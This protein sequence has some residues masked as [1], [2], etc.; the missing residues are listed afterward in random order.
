M[1]WFPTTRKGSL[2]LQ[3]GLNREFGAQPAAFYCA[4]AQANMMRRR[5]HG[6]SGAKVSDV[7]FKKRKLSFWI[8]RFH[9]LCIL[10]R[11]VANFSGF[12]CLCVMP[13]MTAKRVWNKV[14][15]ITCST[16]QHKFC[17][18]CVC[19]SA[20]ACRYYDRCMM[21]TNLPSSTTSEEADITRPMAD[22]VQNWHGPQ[23][24]W[25]GGSRG[26][27]WAVLHLSGLIIHSI[28]CVWALATIL[29][30]SIATKLIVQCSW[31]THGAILWCTCPL[32]VQ[33][34]LCCEP[35]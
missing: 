26:C 15:Y 7:C 14:T 20:Y 34:P 17:I 28:A 35:P 3:F 31:S 16:A 9:L 22:M 25:R 32:P 33:V 23:T 18:V 13:W 11:V 12:S 2:G 10:K 4:N 30:F 27:H 6:W 24:I 21:A 8:L 1:P 5:V 29:L 19:V